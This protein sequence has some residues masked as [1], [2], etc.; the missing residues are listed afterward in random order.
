MV[1]FDFRA[2][3]DEFALNRLFCSKVFGVSERTVTRWRRLRK[4]PASALRLV[5]TIERQSAPW[6]L[7]FRREHTHGLHQLAFEWRTDLFG[8]TTGRWQDY[9]TPEQRRAFDASCAQIQAL[10]EARQAARKASRLKAGRQAAETR[11]KNRE[12]AQAAAAALAAPLFLPAPT[13]APRTLDLQ[14]LR[15]RVRLIVRPHRHQ[16]HRAG[17]DVVHQPP[18]VANFAGPPATQ[19]PG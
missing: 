4:I 11:R 1:E 5:R 13:D 3:M 19:L 6:N 16:P 17:L 18:A 10:R 9:R 8:G 14:R 2:F 7:G 15:P 12:A